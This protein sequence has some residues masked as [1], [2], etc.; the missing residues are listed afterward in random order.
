VNA[1]KVISFLTAVMV[2]LLSAVSFAL[3][4][5]ALRNLALGSGAVLPSLSWAWPLVVD[6]AM[7]V[8]S[9]TILRASLYGERTWLQWFLVA[10]FSLLS[11]GLNVAHAPQNVIAWIVAGV[12]PVAL[13]L[14]FESLMSQVRTSVKRHGVAQTLD[15]MTHAVERARQ[16]LAQLER[17]ADEH[18]RAASPVA[19]PPSPDV[20]LSPVVS[21]S[22]AALQQRANDKPISRDVFIATYRSNGHKSVAELAREIGVDVRTAQR[23]VKTELVSEAA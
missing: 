4:Y 20:V 7:V 8:F 17:Q 21:P 18:D 5:S 2:A 15:V 12:S 3:S 23:W 13:L 19:S 16:E 10:S 14:S 1:N 9:L 6:G 22:D 11:V